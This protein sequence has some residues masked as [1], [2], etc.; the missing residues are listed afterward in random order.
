MQRNLRREFAT[1]HHCWVR[2]FQIQSRWSH[3]S[4]LYFKCRLVVV[5][6]QSTSRLV[7]NYPSV[8]VDW[9][10]FFRYEPS[11]YSC[12]F[13]VPKYA[14]QISCST[15]QPRQRV[16]HFVRIQIIALGVCLVHGHQDVYVNH[17]MRGML[18]RTH[19]RFGVIVAVMIR[20][21]A[22]EL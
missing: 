10:Y 3:Y 18:R 13:L 7:Q 22:N 1:L 8:Q 21:M 17:L 5:D 14:R 16:H 15:Q 2:M 19:V 11:S 12:V 6:R 20:A 9:V 4:Y